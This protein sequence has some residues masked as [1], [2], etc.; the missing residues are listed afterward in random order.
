MRVCVALFI[1]F[2]Q[3]VYWS[4]PCLA[5]TA[6]SANVSA[7]LL[8]KSVCHFKNPKSSILEF[9]ILDPT[10]PV[11][12]TVTST[13]T[14][15]CQGSEAIAT[16][17][18]SDDDGLHETGLNGN[19]MQHTTNPTAFLSYSMTLSPLSGNVDKNKE[20][21]V[22][23]TGKILGADYQAAIAGAYTDL[24]ILSLLP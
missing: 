16:F 11:E 20:Q 18:I 9:G 14:F 12:V 4:F 6:M 23:I 13:A 5:A 24:V 10:S 15:V 17:L 19:R 1:I 21:T 2:L 22:D 3:T 8:S 7:T